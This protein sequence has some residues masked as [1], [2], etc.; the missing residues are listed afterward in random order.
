[1]ARSSIFDHDAA[2]A[3]VTCTTKPSLLSAETKTFGTGR[4]DQ[5]HRCDGNVNWHFCAGKYLVRPVACCS[6]P[7]ADVATQ[8][9]ATSAVAAISRTKRG[10]VSFPGGGDTSDSGPSQIVKSRNRSTWH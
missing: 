5:D 10:M 6:C 3:Q 7:K 1:T 4:S 8:T 9:F 2:G